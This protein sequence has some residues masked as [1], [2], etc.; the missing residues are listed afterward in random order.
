MTDIKVIDRRWWAREE[1]TAAAG[2]Q[3]PSLKPSY[4]EELE[5]RLAEKD[6]EIQEYLS[7]Y[8]EAST[9][10]DESRARLRKET[11]KEIERGRRAM[12]VELLDVLDNLDRAI[13]AAAEAVDLGETSQNFQALLQGILMV[14]Q[15]FLAKLE[16]FG[17]RRIDLEGQR[18]DPARHE[19]VTTVPVPTPEHD[20]RIVG[21]VAHGYA[22][23]EEVLRPAMVA[24]GKYGA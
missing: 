24:V 4:V 18:F 14:Q 8:R 11:S 13:D 21:I 23:D 10:F 1:G 12:L 19:A 22:V 5:K 9:G 20:G 2:S 15:Q 16:G 3:E 7:R 17:I 6:K